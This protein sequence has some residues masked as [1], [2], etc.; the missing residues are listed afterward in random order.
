VL[1]MCRAEQAVARTHKKENA[2]RCD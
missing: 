1:K 2:S